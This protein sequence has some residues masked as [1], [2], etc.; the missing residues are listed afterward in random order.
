MFQKS[1]R[2]KRK[3]EF[4][5]NTY[6]KHDGAISDLALGP[7][8]EA[9][10]AILVFLL[11]FF[12][13]ECTDANLKSYEFIDYTSHFLVSFLDGVIFM[14]LVAEIAVKSTKFKINA[15]E[16]SFFNRLFD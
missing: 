13:L 11:L 8:I 4:R 14:L 5:V 3:R 15:N 1:S 6:L 9:E 2:L 12:P 16:I 10:G 7:D